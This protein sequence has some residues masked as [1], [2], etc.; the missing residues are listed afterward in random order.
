VKLGSIGHFIPV[1]QVDGDRF[2][3]ADPLVGKEWVARDE[4]LR[5]YVFTGFYMPVKKE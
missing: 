5:R 4:L 3:I 2:L 1:L